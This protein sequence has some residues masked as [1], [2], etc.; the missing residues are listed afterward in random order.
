MLELHT[1]AQARAFLGLC[2]DPG[3]GRHTR[4][5]DDLVRIMPPW[6]QDQ[7]D[8]HA[9]HLAELRAEADRL[10]AALTE[11]QTVY[12]TALGAWINDSSEETPAP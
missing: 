9:P 8:G 6:L 11:A 3:P 4:T 1:A 5:L 7:V 2:L 12:A 10:Q